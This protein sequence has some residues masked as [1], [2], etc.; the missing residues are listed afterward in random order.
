MFS[1]LC[2]SAILRG[3]EWQFVTDISGQPISP[4]FEGQAIQ[5]KCREHL[6]ALRKIPEHIIFI[7]WQKPDFG[8]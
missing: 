4:I 3:M 2:S 5:E 8:Q 7:S 6:A 1:D